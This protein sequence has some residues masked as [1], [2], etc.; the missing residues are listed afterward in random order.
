VTSWILCEQTI[1]SLTANMYYS[2]IKGRMVLKGSWVIISA[3]FS[4]LQSR[5][6]ML[7]LINLIVSS[8]MVRLLGWGIPKSRVLKAWLP[9]VSRCLRE[10]EHPQRSR[11]QTIKL[12]RITSEVQD[13][14]EFVLL[15]FGL[16]WDPYFF[17]FFSFGLGISILNFIHHCI[18]KVQN[19]TGFLASKL[20]N[21]F[22]TM[23]SNLTLTN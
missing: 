14:V 23:N 17:L 18:L 6:L 16:S 2:S 4:V 15:H 11:R 1:S 19:L 9:S 21:F 12:Y 22:L 13:T 10:W 3:A 7:V 8:Q 5:V 20:K